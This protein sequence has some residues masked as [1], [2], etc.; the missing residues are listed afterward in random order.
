MADDDD[1]EPD[2]GGGPVAA[3]TG[4]VWAPNLAPGMVGLG[5]E[6]PVAG[7][8]VS[9]RA[10][11]PPPIPD[12]V[13]CE[14]C[15]DATGA[16]VTDADGHFQVGVLTPGTYWL[17]IQKGQFRS[18]RQV[19]LIAGTRALTDAETVL[20][21]RRDLAAGQTIPRIA[22]AVGNN[23]SIQ[24]ILGKLGLGTVGDDGALTSTDGELDFYTNG[25][26]DLGLA[27]GTLRQLVGDLGAPAPVPHRVHPVRR[28][29]P[30][31]P[32]CAIRQ[33]LRNLR[34]Y[35][36]AGGKLYV[37]D[38]S[39]EWMDDVFPAPAPA[40]RGDR[41]SGRST[42]R[43]RPTTRR[44]RHLGP[45]DVRRRRRRLLRGRRRR[46]GRSRA[47]R[48]ARRSGRPARRD[49]RRRRPDRSAAL[50]GVRQLELDRRHHRGAG[51]LRRPG[52]AG[53]RHA[54]GVGH[55]LA[56]GDARSA[57][58]DRHL[59]P[60]R[61]AV[62]SCTR[63]TTPRPA[64]TAGSCRKSACSSTWCSSSAC[65]TPT[66][67]SSPSPPPCPCPCPCPCPFLIFSRLAT[68]ARAGC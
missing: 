10:E 60:S 53:D 39:G 7:A 25:G 45:G 29:T 62:G 44:H 54:Q 2:G 68:S 4:T 55:R 43:P 41:G 23:D 19:E 46:R 3:L 21:S 52:P 56:L 1:D 26:A 57:T 11:R 34:D 67:R 24:D 22:V 18:E 40:R 31:S 64:A 63:P 61:V 28:S 20:P 13:Y 59:P 47:D 32:R 15:A 33:V 27:M 66:R 8:V 58:A 50:P 14:P 9:L 12:G 16:A 37:T 48:L 35:V 30:T 65:A 38:W 6:I 17:V 36:A 5:E 49:R 42:R 51:R